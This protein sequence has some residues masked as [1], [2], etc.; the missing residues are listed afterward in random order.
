NRRRF[1]HFFDL[2]VPKTPSVSRDGRARVLETIHFGPE[3]CG[4]VLS[5]GEWGDGNERTGDEA[6]SRRQ[7]SETADGRCGSGCG[8]GAASRRED[9]LQGRGR[10]NR[11][12]IYDLVALRRV[13]INAQIAAPPSTGPATSIV[14]KTTCAPTVDI[15]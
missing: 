5:Q 10:Y 2:C 8:K 9:N 13:L 1:L 3:C 7:R 15:G 4:R 11:D 6:S 12:E 14:Q